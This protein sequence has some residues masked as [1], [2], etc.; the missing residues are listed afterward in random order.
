MDEIPYEFRNDF[1][2]DVLMGLSHEELTLVKTGGSLWTVVDFC[3]TKSP[4]SSTMTLD[5]PSQILTTSCGILQ[6][7]VGGVLFLNRPG[8][9]WLQL[10]ET[11]CKG[12]ILLFRVLCKFSTPTTNKC[13]KGSVS[14]LGMLVL[15]LHVTWISRKIEKRPGTKRS[16]WVIPHYLNNLKN[17]K[18]F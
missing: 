5:L 8:L 11:E 9:Q 7:P 2:E 15:L 16:V 4:E 17:W 13:L 14:S 1:V 6:V 18:F 12:Y 10:L 3:K